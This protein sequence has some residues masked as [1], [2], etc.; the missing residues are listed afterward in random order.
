MGGSLVPTSNKLSKKGTRLL[1]CIKELGNSLFKMRL[2]GL[3]G[4]VI[5]LQ[6]YNSIYNYK[7]S[8][9]YSSCGHLKA[10]HSTVKMRNLSWANSHF[11]TYFPFSILLLVL[12]C[13]IPNNTCSITPPFNYMPKNTLQVNP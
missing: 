5:F 9:R 12:P 6:R 10:F 3:L 11:H 1:V 8:T 2:G 4:Y 13:K 7:F